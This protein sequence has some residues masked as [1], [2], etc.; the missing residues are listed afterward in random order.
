MYANN[1]TNICH[2]M[3]DNTDDSR[4]NAHACCDLISELILNKPIKK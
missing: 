3:A 1:E 2:K 4:R